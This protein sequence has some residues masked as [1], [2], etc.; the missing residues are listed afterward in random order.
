MFW[1]WFAALWIGLCLVSGTCAA[2]PPAWTLYTNS[3]NSRR[4]ALS[5]AWV[6][7][8]TS[9]GVRTFCRKTGAWRTFT[10]ADGLP[11][12]SVLGITFDTDAPAVLWTASLHPPAGTGAPSNQLVLSMIDLESGTVRT[13]PGLQLNGI[14][15]AMDELGLYPL[16][17]T[18]GRVVAGATGAGQQ[19]AYDSVTSRWSPLPKP[20]PTPA[21]QQRSGGG[22]QRLLV[23]GDRVLWADARG[24]TVYQRANR[25]ISYH[26]LLRDD[27]IDAPL[28][29]TLDPDGLWYTV[30]K[31]LRPHAPLTSPTYLLKVRMDAANG[32]NRIT[33]RQCI[34][35]AEA[36]RRERSAP[37]RPELLGGSSVT[38]FEDEGD[39]LWFATV[40]HPGIRAGGVSRYVVRER[41]WIHDA[42]Q[43][44][45]PANMV[46]ELATIRGQLRVATMNGTGAFDPA[47]GNW[48]RINLPAYAYEAAVEPG[49]LRSF[50]DGRGGWIRGLA[51]EGQFVWSYQVE[52]YRGGEQRSRNVLTRRNRS[53]GTLEFF[54]QVPALAHLSVISVAPAG[55]DLWLLCQDL[56]TLVPGQRIG[57]AVA[58]R[59]DRERQQF[60]R[61]EGGVLAEAA[62]AALRAS[63][64]Y[65]GEAGV[66]QA[67]GE[68]WMELN[69]WLLKFDRAAE[70]WTVETRGVWSLYAYPDALWLRTISPKDTGDLSAQQFFRW[71]P[72]DAWQRLR[73]DPRFAPLIRSFFQRDLEYYWFAGFG[74]TRLRQADA[75]FEA[76]SPS[77]I[78]Q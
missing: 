35:P 33:S 6:A 64:N 46:S 29:L 14:G 5:P 32:E 41:R 67:A 24:L 43:G 26:R 18:Q 68:T 37:R 70:T 69:Q 53:D 2:N 12:Y 47:R 58:V 36:L 39:T 75:E 16:V 50:P 20:E 66:F 72:K 15:A 61:Y 23:T 42:P 31:H 48:Q 60:H 10:I 49:N 4:L 51:E 52:N 59:W 78:G 8:A 44:E 22:M 76:L 55:R 30:L 1:K 71:Q 63:G 21:R 77:G 74:V 40:N 13:H 62:A 7:V 17:A 27:Q 73:L 3:E 38:D 25:R 19:F 54:D 28:A 57:P 56:R 11:S 9:G 45:I 65:Q 34:S